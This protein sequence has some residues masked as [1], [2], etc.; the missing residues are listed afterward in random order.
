MYGNSTSSGWDTCNVFNDKNIDKDIQADRNEAKSIQK[1]PK[2]SVPSPFARFELVQKA[3][4]NVAAKILD[5]ETPDKRDTILV[6]HSLDVLQLFFEDHSDIDII[7]WKKNDALNELCRSHN[8]GHRLFGESLKLYMRQ[9]NYGFDESLYFSSTGRRWDDLTIYLLTYRGDVLGCTSPTSLFMATPRYTE[10]QESITI[11]SDKK[12]F[13]QNRSLADRD[14]KFIEYVYKFYHIVKQMP[15]KNGTTPLYGFFDYLESQKTLI[16]KRNSDLYVKINNIDPTYSLENFELEYQENSKGISVLGYTLFQQKTEDVLEQIA[17]ESDFIIQS[18]KSVKKPLVLSNNCTYNNWAYTSKSVAW[19][20]D[21]HKINYSDFANV[22]PGTTTEYEGGWL[23][24]AHFFSNILV[25]LPYTLDSKHFFDGNV[26]GENSYLLPLNSI[27]FEYFDVSYLK[28]KNGNNF[29]FSIEE[30]KKD[31]SLEKVIVKL[32]I[33]VKGGKPITLKKTYY[34]SDNLAEGLMNF[35]LDDDE[36]IGN[37]IEAPIALSVF[38]FEK[39]SSN[40]HYICQLLKTGFNWGDF[41]VYLEA[42]NQR[43]NVINFDSEV[44]RSKE[45][46]YYSLNE[47]IEY[48]RVSIS[49]PKNKEYKRSHDCVLLPIWPVKAKGTSSYRF[50]FDFG[51]TNSHISVMNM[52]TS[53]ILPFA[54]N[55]SIVSTIAKNID[56]PDLQT[57]QL[58]AIFRQ[59]FLTNEIKE[60]VFPL[61]TVMSAPK[62]GFDFD[63]TTPEAMRHINVPLIYGKEDYGKAKN[64]IKPNIKWSRDLSTRKFANSFIE[65]LVILARA[66]ALEN[67]ADLSKCSFVWTYP[68]SMKGNDVN[69]FHRE[70]VRYYQKYFDN[71]YDDEG[72]DEKKVKRL[73]ESIAPYMFYRSKGIDGIMDQMSLS[74]DIGGGTCDVV[75]MRSKDDYKIASFKFAADVIF[76]AGNAIDNK[77]IQTHYDHFNKLLGGTAELKKLQQI[78]TDACKGRDIKS[79]EANSILFSLESNPELERF[80]QDVSYNERLR[81]D[82]S[83]KIIFLYFYSSIIYYL[84]NLL[85]DY[86]YPQPK[87]I[88]FSGTGSK[89]LNIIGN[90]DTL[91]TLTSQL[92]E[93]FS[94]GS[95][96]YKNQDYLSIIIERKEPKQLTAKG[97]LL[98]DNDNVKDVASKFENPRTFSDLTLRYSTLSKDS[99]PFVL[100]YPDLNNDVIKQSIIENVE[101]FNELF[102]KLVRKL[103]FVQDY[104]CEEDSIKE[105]ENYIHKDLEAF[106]NTEI[107]DTVEFNGNDDKEF[108]DVLFF[109]PIKGVIHRLIQ[110]IK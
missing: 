79:T 14:E 94:E 6:T 45:S 21:K 54:L 3:F 10:F 60:N 46:K 84:T 109:Y 31:K 107:N 58:Q 16:K 5:G 101:H 18:T 25:Q 51:T 67:S 96:L 20:K 27:F 17:N 108:E 35:K 39:L 76:G 42:Y 90:K 105:L 88:L 103:D 7:E 57:S 75:I 50:S 44:I 36:S 85:K 65:E 69:N 22:L 68:L 86:S 4:S 48:L 98:K 82:G 43:D 95:Y 12:I 30:I 11:E 56:K 77:M 104:G 59:E 92:I 19:N 47:S 41:D 71:S 87:Q 13:T 78:L 61:R 2:V 63:T 64:L 55:S 26:T 37:I 9:E 102:L 83:R 8:S 62:N 32:L 52:E 89:L 38:P 106:L 80:K 15:Y 99:V 23:C 66:Y 29:N 73:T 100:K 97:A 28:G 110:N 93:Y 72:V 40:N 1:L 34:P 74:I 33:P 70:W 91:E 53:Q 24:E 81:N 49:E